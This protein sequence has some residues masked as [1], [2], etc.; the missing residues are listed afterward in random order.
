MPKVDAKRLRK[1]LA[2]QLAEVEVAP[3]DADIRLQDGRPQAVPSKPGKEVDTA[4]LAR[5]LLSVLPAAAPRAVTAEM[6]KVDPEVEDEDIEKLRIVEKVSSFTTYFDG[7]LYSPRSQNIIRVAEMV[8]GAVVWPGEIFSL[9]EHTGE[10]NYAK[11]FQDAPVI[12]GGRLQPGVGGGVSQFTTTLFNAAYYAGLEDVEH[13]PHTIHYT[14]YPPVIE[15]TIF[16]P[17]LD[18]KFRNNTDYG[19]L[20][21]TSYTG[22]SV[23]VTLWGTKV[24]DEVKTEWSPKRDITRPKTLYVEP[25]PTCIATA[26]ID[27]FTQDAWRVFYQNGIEVKREKFTWRYDPQPNVICGEPLRGRPLSS[28]GLRREVQT[29]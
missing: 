29:T 1:G 9:N 14:R 24:W 12:I 6:T 16:Y 7:G 18:L 5:D 13:H 4:A 19:I 10:R 27:G 8:D 22:G 21:D 15:A 2:D 26:G 17:T 11:G 20:I 3:R 25:G 28:R 23:T